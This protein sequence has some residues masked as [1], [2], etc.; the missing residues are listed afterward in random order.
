MPNQHEVQPGSGKR[1]ANRRGQRAEWLAA[2]SLQLK[3]YRIVA[4]GMRTKSGEIDIIAK[5]G[6]LVAI[7]EVK[8]RKNLE[9]ALNAVNHTSQQRIANAAN[10]WLAAQHNYAELSLRFDIIAVLPG[11]WPRHFAGA[12]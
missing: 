4:R 5:K 7:V 12:F 8:Y 1:K 6:K 9:D 3:G 10:L 2:F 11:K